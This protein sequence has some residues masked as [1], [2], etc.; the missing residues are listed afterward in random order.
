MIAPIDETQELTICM[1]PHLF[2]LYYQ[3]LQHHDDN[4]DQQVINNV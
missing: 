2:R 1:V 4:D 3:S